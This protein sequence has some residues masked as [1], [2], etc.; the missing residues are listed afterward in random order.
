MKNGDLMNNVIKN[1]KLNIR[2]ILRIVRSIMQ[3]LQYL[4]AREIYHCDIK[5]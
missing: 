3:C 4:L 1:G 5:P 2:A